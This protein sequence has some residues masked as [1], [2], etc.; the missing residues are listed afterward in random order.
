[1]KFLQDNI[2]KVKLLQDINFKETFKLL[3]C[4]SFTLKFAQVIVLYSP[5]LQGAYDV[6]YSVALLANHVQSLCLLV[7]RV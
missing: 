5:W 6:G 7:F 2:F 1:M 3:S 4:K